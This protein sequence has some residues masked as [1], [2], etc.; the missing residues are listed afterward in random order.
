M[1][2][3]TTYDKQNGLAYIAFSGNQIEKSMESEDELFVLDL[4]KNGELVGIEILS[5]SRLQN[6]FVEFSSSKE[7]N[8]SPEMLPA[9]IIPFV[10]SLYKSK[11]SY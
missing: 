11:K 3:L 10:I 4:D 7:V 6:K 1:Y 8:F 5:V 9:Y 2:P